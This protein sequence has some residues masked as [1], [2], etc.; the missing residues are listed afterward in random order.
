[1]HRPGPHTEPMPS[2]IMAGGLFAMD[3]NMFFEIGA[4]DPEMQIYGGEEVEISFRIWYGLLYLWY[5]SIRYKYV[6]WQCIR[7][8]F[9]AMIY[10]AC[11]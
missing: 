3:R 7:G 10:A 9:M 11:R 6:I 5:T 4:Y 1:M 8:D 2:P